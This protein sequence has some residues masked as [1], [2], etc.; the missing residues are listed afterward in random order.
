[1]VFVSDVFLADVRDALLGIGYRDDLLRSRYQFA[2]VS[3]PAYLVR[4]IPLAAFAQAPPSY[5]NACL[6]VA[7]LESEDPAA[8]GEFRALGAPQVF[9]VDA[10]EN[11][12]GRWKIRAEGPPQL[13]EHMPLD[14]LPLRI[15]Y[16]REAWGPEHI[17]RAKSAVGYAPPIQLDF[18]D[19]GLLPI[20]EQE[21]HT[22]LDNLL[23]SVLSLGMK[24]LETERKN[25]DPDQVR[26]LYRLVFRLLAAKLL[27]DRQHPGDWLVVDV[28]R[29]V[30]AVEAFYF[31]G[32]A[33]APEPATRL[34]RQR[35]WDEMRSSFHLQNLSVEV[36][37]YVYENTLVSAETRA[38]YGTHATPPEVAE[39]V[40][41][42][43]PLEHLDPQERVVFEPFAGHAPFLIAALGRLKRL[44]GD[45]VS[46]EERHNY[47]VRML[48][49][50][51]IDSFATEVAKY[52]LMLAD[53]PNPDGWQVYTGD[54]FSSP[55]FFE[56]L[57]QARIVL[58]NPPYENFGEREP[59]WHANK[60]V[61]AV[62]RILSHPPSM[63]G[64]VLPRGFIDGQSFRSARRKL[65]DIY[66]QLQMVVLPDVTFRHSESETV[67]VLA[68]RPE[69]HNCTLV[70]QYVAKQDYREFVRS[71]TPTWT[72]RKVEP[73]S[74]PT[75]GA[76]KVEVWRTPLTPVW[77]RLQ[78]Y[79]MLGTLLRDSSR[80]IEYTVSVRQH[81]AELVSKVPRDNFHRAVFSSKGLEPYLPPVPIYMRV[82]A[83]LM[84]GNAY[85]KPWSEPKILANAHRLSRGPW[86]LAGVVDRDGLVGYQ[87]VQG[88]WPK[89]DVELEVVAAIVNG[90]VANAFLHTHL[91]S[92]RHNQIGVV[93]RIPVPSLPAATR[94]EIVSLVKAYEVERSEWR[95][96]NRRQIHE[97][98]CREI[99][100][101]LDAILLCAYALAPREER[102]LL[103]LFNGF[104]RPGPVRFT[105]YFPANFR[106][107]I[108]WA[109]YISSDFARA[110]ARA[111]LARLPEIDDPSISAA[112]QELSSLI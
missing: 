48:R 51:E 7:L 81:H 105:G 62:N 46:P 47:F 40:V 57:H 65:V 76:G 42:S 60:A 17:L 107:A 93:R 85:R 101:Q 24:A 25:A 59:A 97:P 21:A 86:T 72:T 56:Q 15:R 45:Q 11:R 14:A 54:A 19:L 28:D 87:N 75:A 10:S 106:P 79:K 69:S 103:D 2:D 110:S 22:K 13:L 94:Q 90:P 74:K 9:A 4:E 102:D 63:L 77:E 23:R 20:L 33:A 41:N 108:P 31:S 3:S 36:L 35:I 12:V 55:V 30:E 8:V 88:L 50:L 78:S 84:G 96:D 26:Q 52:S 38:E 92:R 64:L 80:G 91:T 53:Y 82:D 43:L 67:A 83:E 98:R 1:V 32:A 16:E 100:K 18:S 73:R 27:A 5:R 104:P 71:G 68:S 29:A 34:A 6:G 95:L 58:S 99:L 37:A 61:E 89:A 39:L 109:E 112:M 70:S 66:G 44:L 111:T 49:G